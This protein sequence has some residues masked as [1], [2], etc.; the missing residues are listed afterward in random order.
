MLIGL[1]C[2]KIL[3]AIHRTFFYEIFLDCH[4]LIQH[5]FTADV[6]FRRLKDDRE[7]FDSSSGVTMTGSRSSLVRYAT[8]LT[9]NGV[10]IIL[11]LSKDAGHKG[12]IDVAY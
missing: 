4:L 8:L 2:I 5:R 10:P 11:S 3:H 12:R 7:I 1:I 6:V 9:M